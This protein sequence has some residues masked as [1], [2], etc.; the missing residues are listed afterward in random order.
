MSIPAFPNKHIVIPRPARDFFAGR[1]TQLD[2]LDAA[3]SDLTQATQQRF[4]ICEL[5]GCG[6]IELASK[7]AERARNKFWGVFFVDGSSRKNAS[8]VC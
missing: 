3:F 7:Y 1:V 4:V 6:K 5:S 2:M 8:M